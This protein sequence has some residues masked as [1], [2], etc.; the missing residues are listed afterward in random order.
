MQ[1]TVLQRALADDRATAFLGQDLAGAAR[2]GD[3]VL[4]AGDLGSGKTTLARAFVRA[5]AADPELE[6]PSPTFTLVQSYSTTPPVQHVDLYRIGAPEELDELGLFGDDG[7]VTLVEW[8]ERADALPEGAVTVRLD[9]DGEGRRATISGPP[10]A[11]AR[12]RRSLDARAFLERSGA[13]NAERSRLAGDASARRYEQVA[14]GDAAARLLV[15]APP[16]VLGPPVRDGRAYA[17]IAHTAR[18]AG[19]FVAIAGL[20]RARGL[21][22]PEVLAADLDRGFLLIEDLGRGSFLTPAGTPVAE[23]YRAAAEL[24]AFMH[25]QPWPEIAEA[26]GV[27]HPIPPFDR[28]AMLIEASLLLDWYLPEARGR[29]AEPAERAAFEAAWDRALDRLRDK[30]RGFVHRDFQSTN[31]VWREDRAGRERLGIIDFQD[32]LIGPTAYDVASIALDARADIPPALEQATVA[33]YVAARQVAGPF[34]REAFA[35]AY[36]IMAAQR[37]TKILGIFVR[38]FR[39]DGKP[40]YVA[41]LP[42]IRGYLKRVLSHPSLA[43]L[44]ALY[45]DAGFLEER[46]P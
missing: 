31:I 43:E 21:S 9:L 8:P 24:L 35:E 33:A 27:I 16:L 29:A 13:T 5:L 28:Q 23:R 37:N 2:A 20:L 42:R 46:A 41:H 40:D 25:G 45:R 10:E 4:L 15:D 38:L 6:V 18:S 34:D 12:I 22:V 36:A 26:G 39:R 19:A 3:V 11:L 44:R 7:V 14:Q 30:E 32:A 1:S 17:E